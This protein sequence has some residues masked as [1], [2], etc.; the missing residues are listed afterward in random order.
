MRYL[1]LFL[2]AILFTASCKHK[3]YSVMP[4]KTPA[5]PVQ[6]FRDKYTGKFVVEIHEKYFIPY[7]LWDTTYT[8]T[9]TVVSKPADTVIYGNAMGNYKYPSVSLV[10]DDGSDFCFF[11]GTI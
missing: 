7:T 1:F 9:I 2:T 3:Q 6:D 5:T 8:C 4:A 11:S 10:K